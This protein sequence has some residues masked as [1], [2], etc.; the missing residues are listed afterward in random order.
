MVRLLDIIEDYLTLNDYPFERL[1]GGVH[2]Q[3]RQSAIDRFTTNDGTRVRV[4][5][6]HLGWR[7][8]PLPPSPS[9]PL[10][11]SLSRDIFDQTESGVTKILNAPT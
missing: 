9:P 2:R 10:P 7:G 6:R 5:E 4:G 1:D 8:T 11:F 3:Q